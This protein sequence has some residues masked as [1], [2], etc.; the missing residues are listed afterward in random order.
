MTSLAASQLH[1]MLP[2]TLT[3]AVCAALFQFV[4]TA[5]VIQQRMRTRI[6]LLDGGD[7]LLT[8]RIRAHA[9]FTESVPITLLL[10]L[11][12]EL[13]GWTATGLIVSALMLGLSRTLHAVG[14]LM[15]RLMWARKLGMLLTMVAMFTLALGGI[16]MLLAVR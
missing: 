6:A 10:M 9:N 16:G 15:P 14:I 4:L 13:A 8:R 12:L 11:L 5:M 3:T 1:L 2:I 7:A